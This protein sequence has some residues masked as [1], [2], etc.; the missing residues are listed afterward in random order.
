MRSVR[1]TEW[2]EKGSE[3]VIK[4]LMAAPTPAPVHS[5][6]PSPAQATRPALPRYRCA[7]WTVDNRLGVTGNG[8]FIDKMRPSSL[9][10]RPPG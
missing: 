5:G 1:E 2:T 9:T 10:D 4:D 8:A 7:V 3:P 6:F